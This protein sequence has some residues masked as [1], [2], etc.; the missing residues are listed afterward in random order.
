MKREAH[1]LHDAKTIERRNPDRAGWA[2]AIR[3]GD[4]APFFRISAMRSPIRAQVA[5]VTTPGMRG[6]MELSARVAPISLA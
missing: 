2:R 4:Q 6:M 1:H 3:S 5:M